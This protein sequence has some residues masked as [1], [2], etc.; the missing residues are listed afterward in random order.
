MRGPL[1]PG[2][3]SDDPGREGGQLGSPATW[4]LAGTCHT[5]GLDLAGNGSASPPRHTAADETQ[6]RQ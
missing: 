3:S 4:S 6:L 1:T 2:G 5:A